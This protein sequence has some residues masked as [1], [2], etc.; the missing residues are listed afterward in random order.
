MPPGQLGQP[1]RGVLLEVVVGAQQA[2][3]AAA[4]G[5][6]DQAV[7]EAERADLDR[8]EHVRIPTFGTVGPVGFDHRP[9]S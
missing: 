3:V 4:V 6:H 1:Q 2:A 8:P 7:V 5:W 9:T